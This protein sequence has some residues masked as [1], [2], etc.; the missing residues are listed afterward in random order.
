MSRH[1][2]KP[3]PIWATAKPD[4]I[5]RRFVQI[6]ASFLC[7]GQVKNLPPNAF[8]VYVYM[9]MQS[10]GAIEFEMPHKA[11]Q[12]FI[13]KPSFIKAIDEL[14]TAGFI[15]VVQN[16]HNLR[17]PNRYRFSVGWKDENPPE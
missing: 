7:A 3:L 13:S 8:R 10:G 2:P 9:M 14:M 11:Y 12:G 16:G 6:G 4:G 17:K 5:E 1:I 15:D